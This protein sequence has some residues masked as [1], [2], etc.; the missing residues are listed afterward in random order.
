MSG[1]PDKMARDADAAL[2]AGD[3]RQARDLLEAAL[4]AAPDHAPARQ[5]YATLLL[6][7]FYDPAGALVQ[8]EIL[9]KAEP[10]SA[11]YRA[12]RAAAR[13]QIGDLD[14]ALEDY[15]TALQ[16][17]AADAALWLRYGHALKSAGRADDAVAAYRKSLSLKP[18]GEGWW[19]LAD[20]KTYRFSPD[21]IAAMRTIDDAPAHFALGKAL[22]D[23]GDAAGAFAAYRRGNAMKRATLRYDANALT[24]YVARAEK[25]FTPE[26][27][28][29]R[30][31]QG[32][33]RPD[34]IFVIGLPRSGSTLVEQILASHSA[35]EGTME[36][37]DMIAIARE[38]MG[39]GPFDFEAYPERLATLDAARLR[40]LGDAYVE[41]TRIYRREDKPFFIDKMPNNFMHAGLIHM[42]LPRAKII[43]VRRDP[44]A[45]CVSA[46]KQH[47]ASGQPFSYDLGDL[48]HCYA[49]YVRLMAH[50]DAVLPGRV[51]RVIYEDL[52]A[53][54][55]GEIR[56]LL[57]ACGVPFEPGVLRF[58]ENRRAVRTASSE[59]VRKPISAAG[60]DGWRMFEP[61][62]AP[63]KAA[64]TPA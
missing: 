56:R 41:R 59:Q 6:R 17:A 30:E 14:G 35:I 46:Y 19:S 10:R 1:N 48:G 42:I 22:E 4:A 57:G 50:I 16:A 61:W 20:L 63:L 29:Q 58:H 53:D 37:P 34:P 2:R 15:E 27:F 33:A 55:E 62:L 23:G 25:L 31:G 44:L 13:G 11:A 52:V 43:D 18:S 26:F 49:D 3:A 40:A 36:L 39:D 54:P 32:T 24:R 51:H 21:E 9:L 7:A 38:A 12:F 28:A 45:C 64:L 47:F 5:R 60:L 8:I